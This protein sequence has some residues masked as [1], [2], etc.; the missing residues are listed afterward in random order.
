MS[1]SFLPTLEFNLP[2]A[3]LKKAPLHSVSESNPNRAFVCVNWASTELAK[4][5]SAGS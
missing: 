2:D 3:R 5:A 4:F 1:L